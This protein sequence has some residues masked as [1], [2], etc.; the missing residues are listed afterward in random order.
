M[1]CVCVCK[2]GGGGRAGVTFA[3]SLFTLGRAIP[4]FKLYLRTYMYFCSKSI[5]YTVMSVVISLALTSQ[6]Y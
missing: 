5:H 4:L 3:I 1:V 2:G 6:M